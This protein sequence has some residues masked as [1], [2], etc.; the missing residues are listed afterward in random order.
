MRPQQLRQRTA[1]GQRGQPLDLRFVN[2]ANVFNYG[3]RPVRL[4]RIEQVST[5][6]IA[7]CG[8]AEFWEA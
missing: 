1:N 7:S 4:V 5:C 3:K 6:L 8:T 2:D